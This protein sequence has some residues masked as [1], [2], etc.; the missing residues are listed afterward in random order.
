MQLLDGDG[1]SSFAVAVCTAVGV[2]SVNFVQNVGVLSFF[3]SLMAFW[4]LEECYCEPG[5]QVRVRVRVVRDLRAR[6]CRGISF[7]VGCVLIP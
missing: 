7:G 4:W 6:L 2:P 3:V 1:P 5:I